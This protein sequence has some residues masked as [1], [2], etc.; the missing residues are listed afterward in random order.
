MEIKSI[1]RIDETNYQQYLDNGVVVITNTLVEKIDFIGYNISE[2][3]VIRHCLIR[4][5]HVTGCWF[6]GGLIFEQC[7]VTV[8]QSMRWVDTMKKRYASV[9]TCFVVSS[10][11]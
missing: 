8:L 11:I 2:K 3:V 10:T 7:V 5:L 9:T 6:E 1:E 4:N